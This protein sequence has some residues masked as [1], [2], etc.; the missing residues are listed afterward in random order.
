M[1]SSIPYQKEIRDGANVGGFPASPDHTEKRWRQCWQFRSITYSY[2]TKMT[3]MLAVSQNYLILPIKAFLRH[4]W[5]FCSLT[6]SYRTKM[7]PMFPVSQHHLIIQNKDGANVSSFSASTDRTEQR[8]HQCFQFRSINWSHRTKMAPMFPVSQHHLII[9]NKDGA[10]VSSVAAS[11]DHTEQRW[12][13]CWQFFSITWSYRTKMAPTFPVSQHQLIIQNKDGANVGSFAAS[14]DHT[15][16][17]RRQC[18]QFRSITDS[19]DQSILA[20]LL[21]VSQPHLV[22]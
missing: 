17:R 6:W 14:P 16:Q 21:T 22:I 13:Q 15:E 4:C 8:W 12:R 3:P 20:S 1:L 9:Q 19:I 2:R 18:W 10:N 5:L 7:A 11:P